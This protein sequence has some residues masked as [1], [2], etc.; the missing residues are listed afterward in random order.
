[1]DGSSAGLTQPPETYTVGGRAEH[2]SRDQHRQSSVATATL[3]CE[4]CRHRKI[5]CDKGNPCGTCQKAG[6]KCIPVNRQRLPRGRNGGRR[7]GD[8]ELKARIGRL[9]S[10]VK[11]LETPKGPE[12]DPLPGPVRQ[13]MNDAPTQ[14]SRAERRQGSLSESTSSE[15]G[16]HKSIMRHM[17]SPFWTSLSTEV[18][19]LMEVLEESSDSDDDFEEASHP[20]RRSTADNFSYIMCG[21]DS[22]MTR[23]DAVRHPPPEMVRHLCDEFLHRIDPCFK[24]F[25]RPTVQAFMQEQRPYLDYSPGHPAIEAVSFCIYYSVT[26]QLDEAACITMFGEPKSSVVSRFRFAAEVT[27]GRA[28]L[29]N[30]TDLATLQAFM[31]FLVTTRSHDTSRYTWTMLGLAVRI[32][33][34]LTLH[35]DD[36]RLPLSPFQKQMRRRIWMNLCI[37]DQQNA[38]DRG[39]NPIIEAQDFNTP[40][41]LNVNDEDL[42]PSALHEPEPRVG[43]TDVTI[44]Y[45]SSEGALVA[46]ALNYYSPGNT[47]PPKEIEQNWAVRW[48][49]VLDLRRH[50][51][52]EYLIHA[53][54]SNSW[55]WLMTQVLE[56]VCAQGLLMSVRPLQRHPGCQA[57]RV[58]GTSVL[59]IAIEVLEKTRVMWSSPKVQP[60]CWWG[61]MYNQWFAIAVACG[62]LCVSS[63]GSIVERAWRIVEPSYAWYAQGVADSTKGKLWRPIEKMMRKAKENRARAMAELHSPTGS[64]SEPQLLPQ[65]SSPQDT[66]SMPPP[67]VMNTMARHDAQVPQI[68]Q[69]PQLPQ[70]QQMAPIAQQGHP[71]PMGLFPSMDWTNNDSW[72]LPTD[73]KEGS[74][75]N[76]DGS[77]FTAWENWESFVDDLQQGGVG[78]GADDTFMATGM[79]IDTRLPNNGIGMQDRVY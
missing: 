70:I 50:L 39:S 8:V 62:E 46:K 63:S 24:I 17:T 19:G 6:V 37:I 40:K 38:I 69:I 52:A 71:G 48:E 1:M 60:W 15:G 2:Q 41:P 61:R 13:A 67:N 36:S 14:H 74:G 7:K 18:S 35:L 34:G 59:T 76:S 5:R 58:S 77:P 42:S 27:L 44:G 26:S 54:P 22:I 16:N 21:P 65:A 72:Q 12:D 11:S 68:P 20:P 73:W 23:P 56:V 28:D 29:V 45:I 3:S 9:E 79:D 57:P 43:I 51:T 78:V 75:S 4:L 33:Q 55:H 66:I 30:T 47:E 49:K 53:D 32:A 25:H 31:L 10:L 64:L